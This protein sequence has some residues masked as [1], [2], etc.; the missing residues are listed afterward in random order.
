MRGPVAWIV[1]IVAGV[2]VVIAVTAM[3]GNRDKSGETVPAGEWA[4]SVCGVVATWRGEMESIVEDIRTPTAVG[5]PTEE[6]QSETPQGR[7]GFVRTG[8]ERAVRATDTMVTGI[9]NAGVPDSENGEESARAVSGWADA[10][11]ND[12]QDA[13][14]SLDT[15][16]DTLADSVAQLTDAARAIGSAI[17]SG[18]KTVADVARADPQLAG[19]LRESST[20]QQLRE[21]K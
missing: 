18:V 19:A 14:D 8:L 20:C 16:A 1:G 21:E 9:D 17:T 13:L 10:T 4:Q 12:L 3:I 11:H 6:P 2:L 7:T 5:G 15:E